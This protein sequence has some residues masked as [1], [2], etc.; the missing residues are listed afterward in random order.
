MSRSGIPKCNHS[1]DANRNYGNAT[2]PRHLN[3]QGSRL[4][5]CL[6][7]RRDFLAFS[8]SETVSKNVS[9]GAGLGSGGVTL[10][11][12]AKLGVFGT[13]N[14]LQATDSDPRLQVLRLALQGVTPGGTATVS[15]PPESS[16]AQPTFV[17]LSRHQNNAWRQ[18]PRD[19]AR[20]FSGKCF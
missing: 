18:L 16:C 13:E 14:A 10:D 7:M 2:R 3:R 6:F 12:I 4:I 9:R 1:F 19:C 17:R 5:D 8:D 11:S 15:K 20:A